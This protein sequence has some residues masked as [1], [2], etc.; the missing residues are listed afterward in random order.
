MIRQLIR[1]TLEQ[2]GLFYSIYPAQVVENQDPKDMNRVL[3][4]IPIIHGNNTGV[5]WAYPAGFPFGKDYGLNYI[6]PVGE[7]VWVQ[8]QMGRL[9][10][11][12]WLP[13]YPMRGHKPEELKGNKIGFKSPEG[14][15]VVIDEDNAEITIKTK[16]GTIILNDGE[17]EGLV[18]VGKLTEK[19]NAIENKI[20][21][22]QTQLKTHSH[23]N[24]NTQS[25]TLQTLTNLNTTKQSDIENEK[26]KH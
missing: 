25:P 26:V 2:Y 22:L 19:L 5:T 9:S 10:N 6:P 23:P 16:D 17:F 8:F 3:L 1:R 11:P 24:H 18:K 14:N 20:N 15:L 7:W 12:V 21:S 4:R 13:G